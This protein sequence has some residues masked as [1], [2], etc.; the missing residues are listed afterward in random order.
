M[1]PP[2]GPPRSHARVGRTLPPAASVGTGHSREARDV[3]S[4][5]YAT[6]PES[7]HAGCCMTKGAAQQGYS[8]SDGELTLRIPFQYGCGRLQ[9]LGAATHQRFRWSAWVWS[10]PPESNRRPHPYHGSCTHR[11]ADQRFRRSP[12]T[13]APQV[14]CST[15]IGSLWSP[16]ALYAKLMAA[17]A[18]LTGGLGYCAGGGRRPP[19]MVQPC[20]SRRSTSVPPTRSRRSGGQRP[21]RQGTPG[22]PPLLP[23]G[24]RARRGAHPDRGGGAGARR[25]HRRRPQTHPADETQEPDA[26]Q[27]RALVPPPVAVAAARPQPAGDD[28]EPL[29]EL[30]VAVL[31]DDR[32]VGQPMSKRS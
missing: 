4:Y 13:I 15:W 3:L 29:P 24:R 11:C 12:P 23:G 2:S 17:G 26:L 22:R 28:L 19:A 27:L 31:A 14:M 20:T 1:I 30:V 25:P 32:P 5:R 10:P 7:S 21:R 16:S 6:S 18:G 9:R 8:R